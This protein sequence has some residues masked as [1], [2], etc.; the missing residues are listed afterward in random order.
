MVLHHDGSLVGT[1]TLDRWQP[2]ESGIVFKAVRDKSERSEMKRPQ[3]DT[4]S[5]SL[6]GS[7]KVQWRFLDLFR[8]AS[9]HMLVLT[10]L[11]FVAAWVPLIILC[12]IRGDGA[13]LSF[14]KDY[15]TQS[16][17]LI[18]LPVLILAERP[19]QIRL[20]MVVEHF[21]FLVPE[22]Q[23]AQF[24]AAWNFHEKWRNSRL[25]RIVLVWLTYATAVW[26]S[27][28]LSPEGSEFVSWWTGGGS[29]FRFL[30]PAGAWAFFVS[31]PILVYFTYLWLWRQLLWAWFL[32][33]VSSLNLRLVAAHPDHLGGLGFLEASMLGQLPFGFCMGVGLAGAVANRVLNE[34]HPLLSFRYLALIL[35]AAALLVCVAPYLFFT[36]TLL[37]MRRQG[38][39]RYGAFA[40]AVGQQFERK[41]LHQ[42]E[43]LNENVLATPDFTAT[44]NLF[45]VVHNIDEIRVIP[46]GLVDIYAVVIV[47]LIPAIPLVIAAIPFSTLLRAA[48][49]LLF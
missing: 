31:Y 14:V 30:S 34:G 18:V 43:T 20:R 21:E 45:S 13:L 6:Q 8:T 1:V 22:S 10:G 3:K 33:S 47:A 44:G 36:R 7:L 5:E 15:A 17:F 4:S 12:A 19:L 9:T 39:L 2:A 40:H 42:T 37:Q 23:V 48:M 24:H 35:V 41:W 28:Y 26:L 25:V 49:K 32:R 29:G 46:V 11:V 38:M 16:R 27:Q